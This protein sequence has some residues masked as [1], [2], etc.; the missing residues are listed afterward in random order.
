MTL[1]KHAESIYRALFQPVL[2]CVTGQSSEKP[3]SSLCAESN[4][5]D[6]AYPIEDTYRSE[7]LKTLIGKLSILT[8]NIHRMRDTSTM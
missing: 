5:A 8:R 6:D 4:F 2:F 3:D 7:H 1:R